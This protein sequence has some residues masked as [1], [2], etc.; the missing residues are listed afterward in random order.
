V[1]KLILSPLSH[2]WILDLDGTLVEHNGYRKYG[3][4]VLLNNAHTL[5]D[6]I[7]ADDMIVIITSR[8]DEYKE[9]TEAFLAEENI[10]YDA[11]IY[12]APYGE[13]I[14]VNDCK[15]SGLET[16]V[17]VNVI[18]DALPETNIV[19]DEKL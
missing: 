8:T 16:A 19:I 11:I 5:L 18:R 12:N 14:L 6:S 17:A 13:R 1:D 10:R 2:T 7:P 3:R 15:P 4:D 9:M